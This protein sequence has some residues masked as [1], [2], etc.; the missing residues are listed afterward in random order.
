MDVPA[1]GL[2]GSWQAAIMVAAPPVSTASQFEVPLT[3]IAFGTTLTELV[4][5]CDTDV[6]QTVPPLS[7]SNAETCATELLATYTGCPAASVPTAGA[8]ITDPAATL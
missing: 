6:L 7:D 8:P 2:T 4:D 5:A 3:L 1:L